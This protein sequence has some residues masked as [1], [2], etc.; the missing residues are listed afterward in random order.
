MH[1]KIN[2]MGKHAHQMEKKNKKWVVKKCNKKLHLSLDK[3]LK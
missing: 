1:V 3:R 2:V